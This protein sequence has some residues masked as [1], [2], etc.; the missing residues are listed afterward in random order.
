MITT[1]RYGEL[2]PERVNRLQW[3]NKA[4]REHVVVRNTPN[5]AYPGQQFDVKI[6]RLSADA[7]IV[8]KSPHITFKLEVT[9]K[10]K[11]HGL[12]PNVGRCIVEKKS[13]ALGGKDV[14]TLDNANVFGYTCRFVYGPT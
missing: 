6:S 7:S 5:I 9:T 12:V 8:P 1:S 10:D 2:N 4:K 3:A 11:H 14:E 13:L